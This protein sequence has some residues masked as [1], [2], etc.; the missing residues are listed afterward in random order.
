MQNVQFEYLQHLVTLPVTAGDRKTRFVLDSGIGLTLVSEALAAQISCEPTGTAFSGK[1]MSG[2]EV[3][4]PLAALDS[5]AIGDYART[6]LTVGVFDLGIPGLDGIEGFLSLDHFR[7]RAVTVDYAS[8]TIAVGRPPSGVSVEV[9]VEQD[10]PSTTVYMPL[11][12]PN[13]RTVSV[14][15]DMGSDAL[16]LDE[17]F[18]A[19]LE[20][21]LGADDVRTVNG[22]DET[23]H[24]YTRHF[25]KLSGVVRVPT[26]PSLAQRDPE[27]MFQ[28]IIY[29]GLAG[30]A[31]LRNFAV[32][33]DVPN[34]RLL[35]A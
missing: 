35:F 11:E 28:R 8:Q 16:I 20:I 33:F 24:D 12:L 5:L 31:F 9:R 29:D 13:G 23:G 2:Q 6:D 17:R 22:R 1:R 14:E 34:A 19:E 32:T 18:A 21:D 15:V 25:T 27:V 10:G 26:A 7:E 3:S 30:H 4:V